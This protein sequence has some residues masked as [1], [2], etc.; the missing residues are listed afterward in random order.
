[1]IL[2]DN[3]IRKSIMDKL[4]DI[5]PRPDKLEGSSVDL[6]LEGIIKEPFIPGAL[7]I[8]DT[9][10]V[11]TYPFY[12]EHIFEDYFVVPPKTFVLGS[13]IEK[14][15]ISPNLSAF[16]QGR[17]SWAR[18]GLAIEIAGF[19]DAGFEGQITLE[20][21]NMSNHGI[22]IYKNQKICQIIFVKMSSIPEIPY[23]KKETQKYMNQK[24]PTES[25]LY[26]DK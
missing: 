17:S 26:L 18:L 9:K 21:F 3:D 11:N 4:I 2:S 25:K 12:E 10:N 14:I 16:V 8:V 5:N 7:P 13:T 24:E 15:K 20:I 22:K 6:H 19:C 23:N 1:M